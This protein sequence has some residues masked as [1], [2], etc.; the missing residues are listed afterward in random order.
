MKTNE[1]AAIISNLKT[2]LPIGITQ[3]TKDNGLIKTG[4]PYKDCVKVTS[5]A[6]MIASSYENAVNNALGRE[7]KQ[8]DF[9]AQ[10]HKWMVRAENNLGRKAV[11]DGERYL[12][13]KVQSMQGTRWMLGEEDVTDK[14]QAYRKPSPEAPATQDGLDKKVIWRTPA[15]STIQTIR[16]LGAEYTIEP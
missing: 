16:M 3:T 4:N 5:Y 6:G 12:P 7:D 1:L 11:D 8:L 13:V 9:L 14:V 2:A 15:L 10:P